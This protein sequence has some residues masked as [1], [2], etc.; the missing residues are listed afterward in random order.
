[1]TLLRQIEKL[2]IDN[3]KKTPLVKDNRFQPEL[4]HHIYYGS[5]ENISPQ[6]PGNFEDFYRE[7]YNMDVKS[8]IDT[9]IEYLHFIGITIRQDAIA[10]FI[11][12]KPNNLR[13]VLKKAYFIFRTLAHYR[14]DLDV[15]N[16]YF[17]NNGDIFLFLTIEVGDSIEYQHLSQFKELELPDLY[18]RYIDIPDGYG[19]DPVIKDLFGNIEN[20]NDSFFIT[21]KAGTGKSTFLHYFAQN[22][23]KKFL[24]TAFTGIA[25]INVGGVTIHSFFKFPLK[26]MLPNDEEIPIFKDYYQNRKIIEAL[27]TL[28]I[29]EVSMLRADL[30]EALDFSLRRNGGDPDKLFGGKQL[31]LVGDIFQLPPIVKSNDEVESYLFS[32]IFN[33]EYFFDSNSYKVLNPI[34]IELTKVFRQTD[35]KFINILDQI[36]L[37]SIDDHVLEMINIRYFP[38]YVPSKDEFSIILTSTNRIA[39]DENSRRLE[40]IDHHE[41]SFEAEVIGEYNEAR[42]PADRT[43][44]LKK[45]AQVIFIKND[46]TTMGGRWVNGTIAKIDFLSDEIIEIRLKD[47]KSYKIEKVT[48]ENRKFQWDNNKKRITSKVIGTFTQ[49]PIKLAWAITIHKSQG[50]TFDNVIVDLGGG[51][52][53]NGQVYTALSRG[54]SL[55]GLILKRKIKESDILS[56]Q[57]VMDFWRNNFINVTSNPL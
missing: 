13:L 20:S 30:I 10:K 5:G 44:R 2:W 51:A 41:Y 27:D 53:A 50:L 54:R 4:A 18:N 16:P 29:D 32:S 25:A 17:D 40:S 23:K 52:F 9:L 22:T 37:C 39:N 14:S 36:R 28:I 12:N 33:S 3:F 48:W 34:V 45:N 21:G 1:M 43:L 55:E 7:A 24:I 8:V 19:N 31:I 57:R 26:P 11:K 42:F 6:C 56:D 15:N 47:D 38:D 49:Y 35:L 46:S